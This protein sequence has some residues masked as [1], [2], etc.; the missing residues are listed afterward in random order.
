VGSP[1]RGGGLCGALDESEVVDVVGADAAFWFDGTGG[2]VELVGDPPPE[3]DAGL[4]GG[5][6]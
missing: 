1:L 3:V 2:G 6:A 4:A 5:V